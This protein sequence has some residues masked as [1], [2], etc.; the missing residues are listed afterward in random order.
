MAALDEL[1]KHS[2]RG[3]DLALDLRHAELALRDLI[4][5]VESSDLTIKGQ[6]ADCIRQ[7]VAE[8]RTAGRGLQRITSKVHGLLDT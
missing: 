2:T 3:T 6:L 4:V 8:A 1:L 5:D 7:F